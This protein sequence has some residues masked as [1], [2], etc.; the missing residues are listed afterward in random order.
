[1]RITVRQ[2]A[3]L[4][5]L[6]AAVTLTSGLSVGI[7]E[8]GRASSGSSVPSSLSNG[9]LASVSSGSLP[10]FPSNLTHFIYIVRENHAF[11]DYLGDCA[12]TINVT[13][14]GGTDYTSQMNAQADVPYLHQWARS[15]SMFDNMYSSI[16]PY[17]TQAHAY[18]FTANSWGGRDSCSNTVEGTG[19]TTQWGIYNSSSVQAGSCSFSSTAQ[20][21][22]STGGSIF[23]RFLGPNVAQS[24]ATPPFLSIGDIVWEF[25]H[26]R[27]SL[28]STSGI[29]GSYPEDSQAVEHIVGCS[30]GWWMNT[31]SGVPD[32]PPT[33]NPVTGIPQMLWECQ[34]ACSTGPNP[35]LDQYAAQSFVSYVQ[36]Y[37]LPTYTFVELFDDHPGSNCGSTQSQAT[38]ILWNDASM[39]MIVQDV[40]NASS[41]YRGNTAIAISEDDT[42]NGQNGPD[43]VNNGRRLPFVM[44][45]SH[46]VMNGKNGLVVHTTFNTSNVL[47]VMERVEMNVNPQAFV[48][49]GASSDSYAFPMVENDYLAEANPLSPLWKCGQPGVPCNTGVS[50]NGPSIS[51]FTTSASTITL[52]GSLW[53]NV[54]ATGGASP[55]SYAYSGLPAGCLSANTPSLACT[56]TTTG[57]YT[58][59]VKVTDTSNLSSSASVSVSVKS[60]HGGHK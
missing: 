55:Y 26:S 27:C 5:V 23:D 51:S 35:F 3:G 8:L 24:A 20:S 53:F 22:D 39:N 36:D 57:S 17:S 7:A 4:V 54:T 14:N 6:V 56:P 2:W 59:T 30:N 33:V 40:M 9:A 31:T 46:S 43:H 58:V 12:S 11:D 21:Y 18:L 34:Y 25:S 48:L 38:C 44:V 52:G 28:A 10:A 13:C 47:A 1:M 50:F 15:Y 49:G 41:P 42:Q 16:D 32:M 29:P 45:A 37:G 60:Q 19:P